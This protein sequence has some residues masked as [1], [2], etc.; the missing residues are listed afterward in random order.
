MVYRGKQFEQGVKIV[1]WINLLTLCLWSDP[2]DGATYLVYDVFSI[3]V[4]LAF[5]V[6]AAVKIAAFTFAEYA[7]NAMK[8]LLASTLIW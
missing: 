5:T 4:M 8:A 1:I 3:L 7:A 2:I 6:E